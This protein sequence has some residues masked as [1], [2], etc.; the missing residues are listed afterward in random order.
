MKKL[1]IAS[2]LSAMTLTSFTMAQEYNQYLSAKGVWSYATDKFELNDS[3]SF[4]KSKGVAGIRI[5]YGMTIP[6][7]KNQLRTELEYGYNGKVKFTIDGDNSEMKAQT[8][9]LNAYYDFDTG[10][11]WRPYLGV[12]LGYAR[13]KHQFS[14]HEE[15]Q[16][17]SKSKGNFAWNMSIGTTYAIDRNIAL[18]LSYRFTDYGKVS[19][20][21][22]TYFDVKKT[23]QRANELN[24]GVR[25]SF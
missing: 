18:D 11:Q 4:K 8:V 9:M 22:H 10:T 16:Y 19:Q 20:D 14:N 7:E 25:Y 3:G 6:L 2:V 17:A 24:F 12:G 21:N 15:Q 23:K 1:F 5:A 13:L